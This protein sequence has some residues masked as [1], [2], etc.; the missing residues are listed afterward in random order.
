MMQ[1]HEENAQ[2]IQNAQKDRLLSGKNFLNNLSN[3][4][5]AQDFIDDYEFGKKEKS[6]PNLTESI[7]RVTSEKNETLIKIRD[8]KLKIAKDSRNLNK[9]QQ[10]LAYEA[11]QKKLKDIN[12]ELSALMAR[13]TALSDFK[14][15]FYLKE[16]ESRTYPKLKALQSEL[17]VLHR[18]LKPRESTQRRCINI[19][20]KEIDDK[21]KHMKETQKGSELVLL[22]ST[23][24]FAAGAVA[25]GIATGLGFL[26]NIPIISFIAVPVK[27]IFSFF[28]YVSWGVATK[29]DNS[30]SM[31][32]RKVLTDHFK[33]M[34]DVTL[35]SA[36]TGIVGAAA[37]LTATFAIAT[38]PWSLLVGLAMVTVSNALW[39]ATT[40]KDLI[41]EINHSKNDNAKPARISGHAFNVAYSIFTTVGTVLLVLAAVAAAFFPPVA[42]A[43]GGAL[44]LAG[45]ITLAMSVASFLAS[46]I[47]FYMA[48]KKAAAIEADTVSKAEKELG[49]QDRMVSDL[50]DKQKLSQKN[51]NKASEKMSLPMPE[52]ETTH[53]RKEKLP[54]RFVRRYQPLKTMKK[55][56]NQ[57][58]SMSDDLPKERIRTEDKALDVD[59]KKLDLS[60]ESQD[61]RKPTKL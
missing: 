42:L 41:H 1:G 32:E 48:S 39:A 35:G 22:F 21:K 58:I 17:S 25:S 13:Q 43:I 49:Q 26:V 60:A 31:S 24:S 5:L 27:Q 56:K 37:L 53:K 59:I 23:I 7:E 10:K 61:S 2:N 16:Y 50:Q 11:N 34:R 4:Y 38:L 29:Y 40:V 54:K 19:L 20:R 36:T 51:I 57:S 28:G 15:Q 52:K 33:Y 9:L 45:T 18:H 6:K 3:P 46:K 47:S 30:L 12:R 55:Q 8:L 44:L 14:I